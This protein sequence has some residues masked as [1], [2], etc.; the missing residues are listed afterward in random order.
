M[1]HFVDEKTFMRLY[2]EQMDADQIVFL[3]E[4]NE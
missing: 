2:L 3:K 1:N 4:K